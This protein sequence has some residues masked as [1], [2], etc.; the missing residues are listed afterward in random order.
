MDNIFKHNNF[1]PKTNHAVMKYSNTLIYGKI[2]WYD[3]PIHFRWSED[4]NFD[5]CIIEVDIHNHKEYLSTFKENI[6]FMK[7]YTSD[8]YA[9]KCCRC[10]QTKE[11]P[12]AIHLK[13]VSNGGTLIPTTYTYCVG[14]LV[15]VHRIILLILDKPYIERIKDI[16]FINAK[17]IEQ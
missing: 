15:E 12:I 8:K 7:E 5:K 11:Y 2:E 1:K 17:N 14:S 6:E 16:G 9:E 4:N 3:D 10:D 13:G